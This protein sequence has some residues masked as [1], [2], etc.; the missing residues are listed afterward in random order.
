MS[1]RILTPQEAASYIKNEDNVGLSGFTAAGTPKVV[2]EA[3]AV[4]AEE[5]HA[6]GR[7]FKVSLFTGAST[8]DHV[9]GALARANAIDRRTPYQSH[10]D[11]RNAINKG[12]INY[13]DMHLSQLTQSL[14]YGFFGD[15]DVAIIEAAD[16]TPEGEITLGTGVGGAPTFIRLAKKID[17]K[18]VV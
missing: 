18:S 4:R 13:F 3:L 8:N 15:I 14:R 1:F 16:V 9:D 2:T 17:R 5:E 6:Q 10:K 11:S 12:D 7:S